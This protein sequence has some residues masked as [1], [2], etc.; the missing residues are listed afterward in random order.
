MRS[1]VIAAALAALLAGLGPMPVPAQQ[2]DPEL[3]DK[4]ERVFRRCQSCHLVDQARN[5][6]GPH[7][8]GIFGRPAASVEGFNYSAAM[9]E[10]GIVW[11][12]ESIAAY[13]RDPRGYI[14]GNRMAFAGLRRDEDVDAV[15]A[16]LRAATAE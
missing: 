5:R 10:S 6:V 11:D 15:I 14:P 3:V 8:V 2:P 9:R 13:I 1:S 12:A 7:L 4:G 16:Y